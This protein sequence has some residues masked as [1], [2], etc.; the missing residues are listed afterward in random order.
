MV[1]LYALADLVPPRGP[2]FVDNIIIRRSSLHMFPVFYPLGASA[3]Y[4]C[5]DPVYRSTR[6]FLFVLTTSLFDFRQVG[7]A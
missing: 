6:T 2:R 5:T 7:K 4:A 3:G 1:P